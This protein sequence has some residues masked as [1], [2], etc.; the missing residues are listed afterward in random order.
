MNAQVIALLN[1]FKIDKNWS[2]Q[3]IQSLAKKTGLSTYQVYKWAWD[4]R[5]K[6]KSKCQAIVKVRKNTQ[7][8]T[9]KRKNKTKEM[10]QVSSNNEESKETEKSQQKSEKDAELELNQLGTIKSDEFGGY[11]FRF[12]MKND[13]CDVPNQFDE[14]VCNVIGI[15]VDLKVLE[16]LLDNKDIT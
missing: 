5:Q 3:E 15:N 14:N 4:Q 1:E 8:L 10:I 16:A 2:K 12:K 7:R 13:D 6:F 11:I 9:R